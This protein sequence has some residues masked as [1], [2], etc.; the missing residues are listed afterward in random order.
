LPSAASSPSRAIPFELLADDTSFLFYAGRASL[1][2]CVRDLEPRRAAIHRGARPSRD[3][4]GSVSK[5]RE[6]RCHTHRIDTTGVRI[7]LGSG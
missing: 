7:N 4:G 1:V 6:H 5:N 3:R 2:R